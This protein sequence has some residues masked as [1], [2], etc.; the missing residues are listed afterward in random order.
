MFHYIPIGAGRTLVNQPHP[1]PSWNHITHCIANWVYWFT[2]ILPRS[3]S[4]DV[5]CTMTIGTTTIV[6]ARAAA[7]RFGPLREGGKEGGREATHLGQI[8]SLFLLPHVNAT[9][10][11]PRE[12]G[13]LWVPLGRVES[14]V[15]FVKLTPPPVN[16]INGPRSLV[17]ECFTKLSTPLGNAV[18]RR[19]RER[20]ISKW[21]H[22]QKVWPLLSLHFSTAFKGIVADDD[23][24]EWYIDFFTIYCSKGLG[25][26]KGII[27]LDETHGHSRHRAN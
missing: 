6:P 26:K 8:Y 4:G 11:K 9:I 17:G 19:A 3:P 21:G 14:I 16:D 1:F 10:V 24:T 18:L 5:R 12:W 7:S 22:I 27:R 13:E 15:G 23:N 2:W 25:V 20:T